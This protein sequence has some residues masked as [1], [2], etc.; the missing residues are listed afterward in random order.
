M[1]RISKGCQYRALSLL[2][3]KDRYP[4]DKPPLNLW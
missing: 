4:R 1:F 2:R 3:A